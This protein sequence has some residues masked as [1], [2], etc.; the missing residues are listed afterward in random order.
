MSNET[1]RG[2]A[3]LSPEP[4]A[5]NERVKLLLAS[6]PQLDMMKPVKPARNWSSNRFK[7]A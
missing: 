7:K 2:G 4:K 1:R 6:K 3:A 5:F